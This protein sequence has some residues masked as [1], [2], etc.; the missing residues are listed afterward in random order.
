[1]RR[2]VAVHA[3]PDDFAVH[4]VR[5]LYGRVLQE[6]LRCGCAHVSPKETLIKSLNERFEKAWL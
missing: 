4:Q 6:S 1:M 2:I 5:R 3:A